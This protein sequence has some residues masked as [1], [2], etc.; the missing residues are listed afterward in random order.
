MAEIEGAGGLGLERRGVGAGSVGVGV[1]A[2]AAVSPP[3]AA[4]FGG[5]R[6]PMVVV[7]VVVAKIRRRNWKHW[8]K[9]VFERGRGCRFFDRIGRSCDT[10]GGA[11]HLGH[12]GFPFTAPGR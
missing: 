7:V 1:G 10:Q 3:P 11:K 5:R 4:P 12:D 2:L 6:A 8:R 9:G